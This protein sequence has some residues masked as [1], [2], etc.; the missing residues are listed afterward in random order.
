V[1]GADRVDEKRGWQ[2]DS[3]FSLYAFRWIPGKWFGSVP[4]AEII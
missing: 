3:M 4:N 2:I 1:S